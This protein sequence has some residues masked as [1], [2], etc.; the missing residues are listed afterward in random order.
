VVEENGIIC[1]HPGSPPTEDYV[2]ECGKRKWHNLPPRRTFHVPS[3]EHKENDTKTQKK[4][5]KKKGY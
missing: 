1:P 5:K 3:L 4:K 2:I